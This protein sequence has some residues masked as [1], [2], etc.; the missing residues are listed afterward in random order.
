MKEI[1]YTDKSG[2]RRPFWQPWG[3]GCFGRLLLFMLL[4]FVFFFLLSLIRQCDRNDKG[5]EPDPGDIPGW[6]L[7]PGSDADTTDTPG[8]GDPGTP[9][10]GYGSGREGEPPAAG[11]PGQIENP[12]PYLPPP[13]RNFIPPVD[14][15]DIIDDKD[16]GTR[17]AANRLNVMLNSTAGDEVFKAF[18]EGFKKA[19]PDDAYKIV[20][21]NT[22]TKLIQLEVPP[23]QRPAVKR[24]LPGKIPDISFKVFDETMFEGADAGRPSDVGF[25]D[26]DLAWYFAPIQAY[27]A[28]EITRGSEDVTI[29]IVDSYFDMTHS[30]LESSRV[31][32]PYSVRFRSS[33]VRPT[34]DC[35]DDDGTF[36]HGTAVATFA[37]GT[38]DNGVGLCGIAP[39]CRIMPIS[40][41]HQFTSMKMLEGL[42]YAIYQGADVVNISI[43]QTFPEMA[44]F[45]PIRE[46]VRRAEMYGVP[47]EDVWQYAF[48]L[49]D[50]RNVTIVWAAGNSDV[51][52]NQDYSKRGRNTVRVAA[53]DRRLQKAS[54]S[55]FGNIPALGIYESTV[56]APGTE[57]LT[58]SPFNSFGGVGGGTSY[59]APVVAGAIG[60][61]KS[62][63]PSLTNAQ[64]IEILQKTGKPLEKSPE[65]GPLLQIRDALL[66]VKGQFSEFDDVKKNR[67]SLIG[68]WQ[69]TDMMSRIQ[70]RDTVHN[71]VKV[72][73]QFSSP[74]EGVV[75]LY[76]ANT[77]G[78][79]YSAP[80]SI[81]WEENRI[82]MHRDEAVSPENS[83]V[84]YSSKNYCFRA[85]DEGLL[86]CRQWDPGSKGM[87]EDEYYIKKISDDPE[88][89][90]RDHE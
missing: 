84:C 63:D 65:I 29:A 46:Q 66:Y 57:M 26:D 72:Y 21:Y 79:V 20:Y 54:F 6:I 75:R 39:E 22:L 40:L 5:M 70:G 51:Y 76:E 49:A 89:N 86:I 67:D 61:M 3:A 52:A 18:S 19:Y 74:T 10:G 32:K 8:A 33:D 1:F 12:G 56:S 11:M 27:D 62:I 69:A 77:T 7:N 81:R 60:L 68:T 80:L 87:L 88:I 14:D 82:L 64:I 38:A 44:R 48:D 31:V 59:A 43:G 58:A 25:S 15:G 90:I 36:Y 50:E 34:R 2:A 16:N 37:A 13:D 45:V 35:P 71:A 55:N 53:V 78:Y 41:G 47:E 30:E 42:L 24:D 28:W 9:G 4:M 73:F 17:I 23:A 83:F 85:D